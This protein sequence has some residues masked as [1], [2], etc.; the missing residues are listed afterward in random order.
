MTL[1][2]VRDMAMYTIARKRRM[3]IADGTVDGLVNEEEVTNNGE[4]TQMI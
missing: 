1:T 2:G 3:H 4:D